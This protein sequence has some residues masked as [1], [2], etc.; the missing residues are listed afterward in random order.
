[1]LSVKKLGEHVYE[2]FVTTTFLSD[3]TTTIQDYIAA[4]PSIMDEQPPAHLAE[5]YNG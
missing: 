4:N 5:R 2:D 3:R 1:L